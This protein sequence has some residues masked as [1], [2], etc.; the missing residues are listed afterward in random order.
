[1]TGLEIIRAIQS[2]HTPL[3]DR[4]MYVMTRLHDVNFYVVAF[5]LLFWLYDKRFVRYLISLFLLGFYWTNGWIKDLA[6]TT[7]PSPAD[8]RQLWPETAPGFAFPSG[9]AQGPI[10][11]YGA[12]A[13]RFR[14][15]WLWWA[16]GV[17]VFLIG[18]SRVYGGLHW[19]L[20]VL[21]GWVIGAVLLYGFEKSIAFWL[22]E[23]QT[24]GQR[25]FWAVTI[26]LGTAAIWSTGRWDM[27]GYVAGD[28]WKMLGAYVGFW[29][30]SILEEEFI[31]F[32]PRRGGG[33]SRALRAVI[34]T[35][36]VLAVKEGLKLVLPDMA[37][38]DTIRYMCTALTATVV[39]PYI[40]TRCSPVGRVT[41]KSHKV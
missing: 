25:L 31:G 29:V 2:V 17:L 40:F 41:G 3:L 13:L 30:G 39:A 20:D 8:V 34:G 21:G 35:A 7:R 9:H 18:F 26:P 14:S 36:L 38:W 16:C 19:P 23:A 12:L 15:R 11:F 27:P 28:S 24:L 6:H 33:T 1:M 10:M 4:F 5:P 22:G 37:L 32:D